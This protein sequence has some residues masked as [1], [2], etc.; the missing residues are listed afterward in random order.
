VADL[1]VRTRGFSFRNRGLPVPEVE[2][3]VEL[4]GPDGERW[5]WGPDD[6]AERV[7]GPAEDFCLLVCRRRRVADTALR[8]EGP[9]AVAWLAIAQCFAGPPGADPPPADAI[10][11][12]RQP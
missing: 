3:R 4:T 11:G 12:S 2:P 9:G 8:A 10:T 7:E 6:A 5:V 1:G